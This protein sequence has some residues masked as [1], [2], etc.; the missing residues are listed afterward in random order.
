MNISVRL[1]TRDDINAIVEVECSDV[2]KWYHFS[3]EGRGDSATYDELTPFERTMHGGPWMDASELALYWDK[4]EGLGI[5][6]FVAE[7]DG[8]VVGHLDVLFCEELPLGSFLLLDVLM[9]HNDYRRRGVASALIKEA[10]DL[11]RRRGF[12]AAIVEPQEYEGPSGLLYRSLGYA[13][14]FDVH[15]LESSV[16]SEGIPPGAQLA[17]IPNSMGSPVKTHAMLCGWDNVST[18]TWQHGH[19]PDLRLPRIFHYHSLNASILAESGTYFVHLSATQPLLGRHEA[20]KGELYLWAPMPLNQGESLRAIQV[21]K[22]LASWLG[23][24]TL[25]TKTIDKSV[26]PLEEA[27]FKLTWKTNQWLAKNLDQEMGP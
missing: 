5:M 19:N 8:K 20:S 2:E 14:A 1:G 17:P 13:K 9:V 10:E 3:S 18:K 16:G 4:A 11:A 25:M 6:P 27:G 15:T 23:L 22:S 12:G 7:I 21:S 26:A 24:E